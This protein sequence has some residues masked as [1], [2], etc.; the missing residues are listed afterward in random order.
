MFDQKC[1]TGLTRV[2]GSGWC[3]YTV[4]IATMQL[5]CQ[6]ICVFSGSVFSWRIAMTITLTITIIISRHNHHV[7]ITIPI[8]ITIPTAIT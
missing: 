1:T 4:S 7:T 5:L 6:S 2:A 8:T 3:N